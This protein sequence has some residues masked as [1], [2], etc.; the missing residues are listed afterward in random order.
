MDNL[1]NEMAESLI[2]SGN[3]PLPSTLPDD[4]APT[5]L[6]FIRCIKPRPKPQNEE[7]RPGLFV[8]TMTL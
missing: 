4:V 8:Y 3:E 2:T 1:M 7:D 6:H 5:D